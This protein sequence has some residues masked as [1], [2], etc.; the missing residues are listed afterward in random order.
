MSILGDFIETPP[1][2]RGAC[3]DWPGAHSRGRPVA[4][5]PFELWQRVGSSEP[6]KAY[7]AVYILLRGPVPD[8]LTLDHLCHNK[9]CVNPWHLE[10]ATAAENVRRHWDSAHA[11][12]GHVR[13]LRSGRFQA[14]YVRDGLRRKAPATFATEGEAWSW[15]ESRRD[16]AKAT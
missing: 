4:S 3:W 16:Q 6:I 12:F 8:G 5:I 14:A 13:K 11:K 9:M 1:P 10:P 2:G 7:R 15:L